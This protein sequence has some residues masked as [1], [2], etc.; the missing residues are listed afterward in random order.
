MQLVLGW[1]A[2]AAVLVAITAWRIRSDPRRPGNGFWM[3]ATLIALWLLAASMLGTLISAPTATVAL[4]IS[5]GIALLALVLIAVALVLNG[6]V[7]GIREGFRVSTAVPAVSGFAILLTLGGTALWVRELDAELLTTVILPVLILPGAILI[8]E[9][10]AYIVYAIAY[11][12]PRRVPEAQAVVV[13][14]AGLSG[15]QVTPLLASRIDRGIAV[16][17]ELTDRGG[18]PVLVLSG[19]QGSDEA[20]S[21]AEA[22]S[23]YATGKGVE[24]VRMILEDTSTTT[25]ENLRNTVAVLAARSFHW[26]RMLVVTSNFHV[27]RAAFFTRQLGINA[28]CTGAPTAIYYVPAGFLR[29]FAAVVVHYRKANLI[30]WLSLSALWLAGP[31]ITA[32]GS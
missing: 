14:G 2:I 1:A 19:G 13:L 26:T 5:I 15:D 28:S 20:L 17:N 12:L 10:V 29:E 27:L 22:M 25:L 24:P 8:L 16:L 32:F 30:L 3:V 21:E 7:V 9:L 23:R 18:D 11:S 4:L 31:I 6:I